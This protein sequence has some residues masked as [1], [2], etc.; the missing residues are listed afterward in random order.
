M[1]YSVKLVH[2]IDYWTFCKHSMKNKYNN[3]TLIN[4][5][6]AAPSKLKKNNSIKKEK[7][8]RLSNVGSDHAARA[9]P[10]IQ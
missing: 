9:P 4:L 3:L 7:E 1:Y 8:K 5:C 6:K 10:S 2:A